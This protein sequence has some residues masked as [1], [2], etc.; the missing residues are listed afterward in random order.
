MKYRKTTDDELT[1]IIDEGEGYMLE[2]KRSVNS[3]LPKELVAF[4]N[5]SGGR[6][7][8]GIDDIG[9]IAGLDISN[10]AISKI[11]DMALSCDPP[12]VIKI[13]KLQKHKL[14]VIH[15]P[16]SA[17]RPHRCSKG[18]YLRNGANSQKMSTADITAFIQAEGK[19]RFDEQ[20]KT[21]LDWKKVLNEKRLK[22][23]L[24]LSGITNRGNKQDLLFNLDAG[25]FKDNEFYFNQAGI[26]LFSKTP[27]KHIFHSSVVC[28]LFKG[29]N[30][31]YIL[32]RKELTGNLLE[33]VEDAIIFLKK[34]LQLRWEITGESLQRKEILELPEV[35]LREALVN[36]VCHRDYLEQGAQVMV[37]IYNP[38]G[39]PK[40]CLQKI[41]VKE[42][43]AEI[44]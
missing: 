13:E 43:Y 42:V 17:N 18:F 10:D 29:L 11:E 28:A 44:L 3:D 6:V 23:F 33:N 12:V 1:L 5:A 19:V 27:V 41:L 34:H 38:G 20:L 7:V 31:T 15:I 39:L 25:D 37:E 21:D 24:N 22:H 26:L 4:A 9:K 40:D 30:K 35:A 36:A 32:D 2:F 14:L 8:I 16:E